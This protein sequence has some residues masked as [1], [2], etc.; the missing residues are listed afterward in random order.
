VQYLGAP[1]EGFND[2]EISSATLL[3]D[4]NEVRFTTESEL[5][6]VYDYFHN[7][8]VADTNINAVDAVMYRNVY[9]YLR[10]NGELMSETSGLFSD[11]GSYISVKLSSAW[12]QIAGIQG[13]ER[14]YKMLILGGYKSPH[15]LKVKFAYDFNPAWRHEATI[16]ADTTLPV[17]AYGDDALYGDSEVYGGVYPLYQ[18]VVNPKIQKCQS[19]KFELVDYKIDENG[20]GLTLSNFCAE[21]G[22]K[23]SAYKKSDSKTFAAT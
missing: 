2:L 18:F 12:I 19:F 4:T 6:L 20:E 15:L 23:D 11:N 10:A 14:F 17:S 22:L 3:A 13:F 9:T 16:N 7:K 1:V 21:V 8:W 5:S